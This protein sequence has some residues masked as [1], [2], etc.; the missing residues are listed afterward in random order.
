M[1]S[2]ATVIALNGFK[3]EVLAGSSIQVLIS[4]VRTLGGS[5]LQLTSKSVYQSAAAAITAG[6]QAAQTAISQTSATSQNWGPKGNMISC[7]EI[8]PDPGSNG[9]SS[10][11]S[12]SGFKYTISIPGGTYTFTDYK[13]PA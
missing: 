1:A 5:G 11:P 12:G 4:E 7:F 3:V 13:T 10:S 8:S 2:A 6:Q 9:V